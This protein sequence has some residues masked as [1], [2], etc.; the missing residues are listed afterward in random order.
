MRIIIIF[1]LLLATQ[2]TSPLFSSTEE[3]KEKPY[4]WVYWENLKGKTMP[5]YIALCR[6]TLLKQCHDSFNIVELNEKN[7]YNY[8]P[9]LKKMENN[10]I[11][12]QLCI[13]QKVDFYRVCLLHEYGGMYIDADMIIMKDLKE[14][15]DKL[16]DYDYVGFGE[17]EMGKAKSGNSYGA[18]QNWAMA[19]RPK[20]I[21]ITALLEKIMERL[22]NRFHYEFI[23]KELMRPVITELIKNGYQYYHYPSAIDGTRDVND[24]FVSPIKIFSYQVFQYSTVNPPLF[25]FL[26]NNE[27]KKYGNNYIKLPESTLLNSGINFALLVKKS[28]GL[29][30]P[31]NYPP[32]P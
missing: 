25:I 24:T 21:F 20:G 12:N 13:A 30:I 26:T 7:I 19:S 15:T 22:L 32:T 11:I 29:H 31:K 8:L 5:G 3:H 9:N 27:L 28:L 2:I 1:S 10:L 23:G 16:N 6:K 17:Y 14:I 18:P 4:L